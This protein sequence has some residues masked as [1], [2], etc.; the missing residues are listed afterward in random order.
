ML[1]D[2]LNLRFLKTVKIFKFSC[3]QKIKKLS[4][5]P[6]SK[7]KGK[8]LYWYQIMKQLGSNQQEDQLQSVE[9]RDKYLYLLSFRN[10]F[11]F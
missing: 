10:V 1:H 6:K 8:T 4:I 7:E 2:I 3:K 9:I 5:N 11:C